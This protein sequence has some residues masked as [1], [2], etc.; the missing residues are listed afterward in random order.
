MDARWLGAALTQAALAG[1]LPRRRA[2]LLDPQ[3]L[4]AATATELIRD[5]AARPKTAQSRTVQP[6]AAQSK[7]AT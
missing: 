6:K 3:M 1:G 4:R 2:E 7:T 5:R